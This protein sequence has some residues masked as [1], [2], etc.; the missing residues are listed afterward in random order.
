MNTDQ[1]AILQ[2][3]LHENHWTRQHADFRHFKRGVATFTAF[4]E[5]RELALTFELGTSEPEEAADLIF[6]RDMPFDVNLLKTASMVKIWKIKN[7]D[8]PPIF[9]YENRVF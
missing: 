7:S 4:T 3:L 1:Q 5:N 2:R 9:F 6:T 8:E